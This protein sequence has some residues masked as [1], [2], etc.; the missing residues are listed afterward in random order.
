VREACLKKARFQYSGWCRS[1]KPPADEVER[2]GS[3][4][5]AT[6]HEEGIRAAGFGGELWAVVKIA[7]VAGEGEGRAADVAGFDG[8]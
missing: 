7:E 5:V 4:F 6:Q 8:V 2:G 1:A 3:A